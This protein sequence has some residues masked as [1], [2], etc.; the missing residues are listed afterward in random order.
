MTLLPGD[1]L[2]KK[3][4]GVQHI[5]LRERLISEICELSHSY[6]EKAARDRYKKSVAPCHRHLNVLPDTG[7]SWRWARVNGAFYYDL[8][9]IPDRKPA[10]YRSQL[11][12]EE[13]LLNLL[14]KQKE[15]E[16]SDVFSNAVNELKSRVEN[17]IDYSDI[18]Y[19][20]YESTPTFPKQKAE[21]L[22][23]SRAWCRLVSEWITTGTF[24]RLG[25]R[26]KEDFYQAC[27]KILVKKN[28]EGFR[29]KTAKSLRKK[30]FYFPEFGD[31]VQRDYLISGK[32]G[33]DNARIVGKYEII[34]PETGEIMP[35]DIHEAIMFEL[36]MNPFRSNKLNKLTIY[37]KYKEHLE[38]HGVEPVE[39]RTFCH[40]LSS[41]A[42]KVMMSKERDG[43]KHFNNQFMPYVPAY[44]LQFAN[45]LW[46]ADGSGT[47][48]AYKTYDEKG[49][50]KRA[51]LYMVR[52]S[53]VASRKMI[54]WSIG[55]HETPDLVKQA[56]KMAVKCGGSY[57]AMEFLSD[58][59]S[60]FT[61]AESKEFLNMLFRKV[62]TINP[63]N[64]QENPAEM[65]VRWF[66]E[67]AREF[68][69]WTQVGFN[70]HNA[71]S[72]ANP[73]YF[74]KNEELPTFEEAI[75]QVCHL[76]EKWNNTAW[77]D[78]LT[79]NQRFETKNPD[80]KKLNEKALRFAFGN[81]TKTNLAY[82]RSFVN[83][84][85]QDQPFK[86]DIPNYEQNIEMISARLGYKSDAQVRVVWDI[87]G[88]DLY[89]MDGAFILTCP[90]TKKTAKSW[91]EATDETDKA[92]GIH[93]ERKANM[94]EAADS[95]RDKV[96]ESADTLKYD[97][98]VT[99]TSF[100]GKVKDDYNQ[101]M[102]EQSFKEME[103]AASV[104][105][106]NEFETKI[107]DESLQ[108]GNDIS[109]EQSALESL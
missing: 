103:Y 65:Y 20:M 39:Y 43:A 98:M 63:G 12:S 21:E 27:T 80:A 69:N 76:V 1:I 14:K 66:T 100:K 13:D 30:V 57:E 53:D 48:L 95:F 85:K 79:P 40:H 59:G 54:G 36:W 18:R 6:F 41:F 47:K 25:L 33:N 92:L 22:A 82:Q 56:V 4:R 29:I 24:K 81:H 105:V 84:W 88:A 96:L 83:V 62:R 75:T 45:S 35:F 68:D 7:K 11:P 101:A 72:Q 38:L 10:F 89:T 46:V 90:P 8:K 86:F 78:G 15:I 9:R 74:P 28:L 51:T 50:C 58:N 2:L 67:S 26:R 42:N 104:S 99:D 3:E 109:P 31:K 55:T 87:E 91:A 16:V 107:P 17:L 32:Y 97:L 60:A 49:T 34:H 52:I 108:D 5:W 19:Y 70:S 77:G 61:S 64:S 106:K 73:D 93:R 71:Q 23:E 37:N 94:A 102:E 44:G